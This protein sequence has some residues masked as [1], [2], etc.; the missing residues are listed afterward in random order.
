M[1]DKAQLA[2][3]LATLNRYQTLLPIEGSQKQTLLQDA[4]MRATRM[5]SGDRNIW[6]LVDRIDKCC[7]EL[8]HDQPGGRRSRKASRALLRA[9]SGLVQQDGPTVKVLAVVNR[10][11]WRVDEEADD[12]E[13]D[14][15][16][17]VKRFVQDSG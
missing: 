3:L 16:I 15:K 7:D 13:V 9:L 14:G 2:E 5:I 17:I 10:A 8:P 11:D 4:A 12:S 1:Q 6:I